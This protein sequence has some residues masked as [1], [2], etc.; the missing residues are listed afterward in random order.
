MKACLRLKLKV[1]FKI[2][3]LPAPCCQRMCQFTKNGS[4]VGP[5]VSGLVFRTRGPGVHPDWRHS[6]VF[7]DKTLNTLAAPLSTKLYK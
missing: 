4:H 3:D 6:A 2:A 5:M 7:L 1:E